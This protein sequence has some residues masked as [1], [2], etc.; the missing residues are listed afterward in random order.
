MN[1]L[2]RLLQATGKASIYRPLAHKKKRFGSAG[3]L[4]PFSI[5]KNGQILQDTPPA[6]LPTTLNDEGLL[7]KTAADSDIVV[8]IPYLNFSTPG[9]L[10]T[11]FLDGTPYVVDEV[12]V[13]DGP[14]WITRVLPNSGANLIPEGRYTVT[15]L[16]DDGLGNVFNGA[17]RQPL[18]ID[19]T[20]PG[21]HTLPV[22]AFD[23][24]AVE[25]GVTIHSLVG[26]YLVATVPDWFD[27]EDF[28]I[29]E[30]YYLKSP[31]IGTA[32]FIPSA[33]AQVPEGGKGRNVEV[34]IPEAALREIG[35]GPVLFGIRLRDLAGNE[36]VTQGLSRPLTL[37]LEGAP[38]DTDLS[39]PL[40]ERFEADGVIDEADARHPVEVQIP[41]FNKAEGDDTIIFHL[42]GVHTQPIPIE[43]AETGDN[44]ILTFDL[45][46]ALFV[47]AGAGAERYN[48][49][50]YY[51]LY[52]GT[53][54]LATSPRPNLVEVDITTPG[55]IDPNPETPENES[56]QPATALGTSEIPN[57]IS[58]SDIS[59]D[60]KVL[61]PWYA[62]DS[63]GTD[64]EYFKEDDIVTVQWGRVT[65]AGTHPINPTDLAA[66]K[67][68]E[69]RATSAEMVSA[70]G[71]E[72]QVSYTVSRQQGTGP[73]N[74]SLSP[75]QSV[76]VISADQLPGGPGGLDAGIFTEVNEYGALDRERVESHGGTP[77]RVMLNYVNVA[78]DDEITLRLQ[79]YHTVVGV[80]TPTPDMALELRHTVVTADLPDPTGGP[81]KY[82][83]FLIPT[84]YFAGKW[85]P[86]SQGRGTVKANYTIKNNSGTGNALE[87]SVRVAVTDL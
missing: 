11:L 79:G 32:V 31:V 67:P 74:A 27:M 66:R 3:K 5:T 61:V 48:V 53:A 87:Q 50:A 63:S 46:Y 42:G 49:D 34:K 85:L 69:L 14:S 45:D 44:P 36:S 37:I 75:E 70:G 39:K 40:I 35:D 16:M 6:H 47:L 7:P 72:R 52:R 68:L 8:Q 43:A 30:P 76:E 38:V 62:I 51:E 21:G 84:A 28:D 13:G 1:T 71:G 29:V 73:V 4:P 33:N 59:D 86:P 60:A 80:E 81:A 56:L 77:F 26:G 54:L 24:D 41:G 65:L 23:E 20:P 58:Q 9:D 64:F 18:R 25:H 2:T 55:G 19:R 12:G 22:I 15:Y 82:H 83:D 10:V 17:P 78:Q 57:R